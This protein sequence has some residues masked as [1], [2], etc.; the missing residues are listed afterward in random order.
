MCLLA[1]ILFS[2]S[3]SIALSR[4]Q[5]A[6]ER[7]CRAVAAA[8]DRFAPWL[9]RLEVAQTGSP[10]AEGGECSA[11]LVSPD[12]VLAPASCVA[13]ADRIRIGLGNDDDSD[14]NLATTRPVTQALEVTFHPEFDESRAG[15][16][17]D[18]DI[19]IVT[20]DEL[21]IN[22][23]DHPN[24]WPVCLSSLDNAD[25]VHQPAAVNLWRHHVNVRDRH[26]IR[27]VHTVAVT[28]LPTE[29]CTGVIPVPDAMRLGPLCAAVVG[30]RVNRCAA[31][32]GEP[33]VINS[34]DN[35]SLLLGIVSGRQIGGCYLDDKPWTFVEIAR[36]YKWLVDQLLWR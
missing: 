6:W 36:V 4:G 33:L 16:P 11:V 9:A 7:P 3:L 21:S 29:E 25:L 31:G 32:G 2:L 27:V 14:N 28:L 1:A 23:D 22:W 34:D 30:R 17:Q 18:F 19:A 8:N 35:S 5:S 26:K 24:I 12:A 10:E 20:F 13:S 15:E